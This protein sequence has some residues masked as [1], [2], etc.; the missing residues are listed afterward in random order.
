MTRAFPG[1][2]LN[3][4]L[5]NLVPA[6]KWVKNSCHYAFGLLYITLIG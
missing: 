3:R 5:G 1:R 4:F 6:L 2:L